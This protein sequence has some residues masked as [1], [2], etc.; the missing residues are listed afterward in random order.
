MTILWWHWLILGLLLMLG[1]L[2]TPGGFYILFFGVGAFITGLLAFAGITDSAV[3]MLLFTVLSVAS[4]LLFR[5]RILSWMQVNPQ[6]PAVD[7]VVG[8]VGIVIGSLPPGA[9]GKVEL[10]GALWSARN[11][12]EAALGS[13]SRCRVAGIDGLTLLVEPEGSRA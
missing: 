13:G 4:L 12:S 5:S 9:F 3:Q 6:A 1:E 11:R 2:A 7:A 10:R 8:E